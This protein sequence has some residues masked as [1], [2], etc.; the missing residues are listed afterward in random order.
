MNLAVRL[1]ILIV[2]LLSLSCDSDNEMLDGTY[3]GTIHWYI[4]EPGSASVYRSNIWLDMDLQLRSGK[5]SFERIPENTFQVTGNLMR[6]N[7][8]KIL[9]EPDEL[10]IDGIFIWKLKGDKLIIEKREGQDHT[11]LVLTK[12]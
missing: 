2:L 12:Q 11:E 7:N 1:S 3:V 6:F 9:N 5:T 8:Y 10:L 4:D